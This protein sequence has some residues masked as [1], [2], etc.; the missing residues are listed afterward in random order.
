MIAAFAAF[1]ASNRRQREACGHIRPPSRACEDG[2][3]QQ[4]LHDAHSEKTRAD[5]LRAQAQAVSTGKHHTSN[6]PCRK[7]AHDALQVALALQKGV[8]SQRRLDIRVGGLHC[9]CQRRGGRQRGGRLHHHHGIACGTCAVSR[10]Q[11]GCAGACLVPVESI[12][13]MSRFRV[14]R[15]DAAASR[16]QSA[17]T[18]AR[19]NVGRGRCTR[20]HNA[21]AAD[22]SQRLSQKRI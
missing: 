11:R 22:V 8:L 7:D 14:E 17:A 20:L 5:T 3:E 18:Q 16:V 13:A 21:R 9:V 4:Q 15:Q 6:R 2:S 1:A 10:L 12:A 19:R